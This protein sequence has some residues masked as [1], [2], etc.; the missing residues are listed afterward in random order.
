MATIYSTSDSIY[1]YEFNFSQKYQ[2]L[3]DAYQRGSI[4]EIESLLKKVSEYKI[5]VIVYYLHYNYSCTDTW[6]Y[7]YSI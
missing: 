3:Y 6:L 5:K 1:S 4:E 2:P 7:G